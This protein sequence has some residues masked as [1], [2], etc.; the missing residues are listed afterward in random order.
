MN[1]NEYEYDLLTIKIVLNESKISKLG[2]YFL[3]FFSVVRYPIN[4]FDAGGKFPRPA[5]SGG[6]ETTH[7]A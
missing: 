3:C 4:L 5:P 6:A 7:H 1:M 2:A